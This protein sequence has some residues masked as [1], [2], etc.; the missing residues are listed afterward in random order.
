MFIFENVRF[1][2]GP[3]FVIAFSFTYIASASLSCGRISVFSPSASKSLSQ[4]WAYNF[5]DGP[6]RRCRYVYAHTIAVLPSLYFTRETASRSPVRRCGPY[7]EIR[8]SC[9]PSD[10][11]MYSRLISYRRRSGIGPRLRQRQMLN[12]PGPE[13][14]FPYHWGFRSV[15]F[16]HQFV[17]IF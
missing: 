12:R 2:H 8:A 3:R 4:S 13:K 14:G 6:A 15:I 9:S 11:V 5:P 7:V 17:I 16:V 1:R 10:I